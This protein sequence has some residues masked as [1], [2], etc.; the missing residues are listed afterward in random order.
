MMF[1]AIEKVMILVW[2]ALWGILLSIVIF[3]GG[4][5]ILI[6][7]IKMIIGISMGGVSALKEIQFP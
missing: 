3:F 4:I 1:K 6:G 2:L 5:F 7:V